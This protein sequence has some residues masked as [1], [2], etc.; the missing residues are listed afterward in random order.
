M[1]YRNLFFSLLVVSIISACAENNRNVAAITL[2]AD[3][4][5]NVD[6][7]PDMIAEPDT[8]VSEA[9]NPKHSIEGKAS[10]TVSYCGGAR[11]TEEV[12]AEAER[13]RVL[14]NTSIKF[15]S[16]GN[17][18][19]VIIAKTD[20]EGNFKAD[21]L[22]GKWDYYLSKDVDPSLGLDPKCEKWFSKNYG[23]V[24]V[25]EGKSKGYEIVISLSCDPC[26]PSIKLRQ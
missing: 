17:K 18:S 20:S 22:P 26:D 5:K 14:K 3:S 21:L 11:P 24:S 7:L 12:I 9:S 15:V 25:T 6:T 2:I 13:L 16:S 10:Y 19:V 1:F 23:D 8:L 4:A